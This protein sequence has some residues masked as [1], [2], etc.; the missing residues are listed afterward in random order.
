MNLQTISKKVI[1]GGWQDTRQPRQFIYKNSSASKST[2]RY[3]HQH[4]DSTAT[5]QKVSAEMQNLGKENKKVFSLI[6]TIQGTKHLQDNWNGYGSES[7]NGF[8]REV[9]ELILLETT[10]FRT[11]D[12]VAPSAQGGIGIFFYANNKYADIECFNEGEVLGTTVVGDDDPIIWVIN[13]TG[14]KEALERI[15]N[16]LAS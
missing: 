3:S 1:R 4:R 7:P 6:E 14:I 2:L 5:S 9:A 11:P 10:S 16:F 13:P 15:G 12:R 8:A